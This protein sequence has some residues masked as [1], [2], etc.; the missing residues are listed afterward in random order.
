MSILLLV[1]LWIS[2]MRRHTVLPFLMLSSVYCSKWIAFW[3]K[4]QDK[5]LHM[6]STNKIYTLRTSCSQAKAKTRINFHFQL[7][8]F[9]S[10]PT[11]G[12]AQLLNQANFFLWS[13]QTLMHTH[14]LTSAWFCTIDWE[15]VS[16]LYTQVRVKKMECIYVI[17]RLLCSGIKHRFDS[18]FISNYLSHSTTVFIHTIE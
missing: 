11:C 8:H 5:V 10:S 3:S 1:A 9:V 7:L 16:H 17:C 13:S 6:L 12:V 14:T 15:M 2:Y 18:K 4:R